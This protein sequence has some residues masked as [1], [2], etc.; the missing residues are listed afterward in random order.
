VVGV[1]RNQHFGLKQVLMPC[2]LYLGPHT[3]WDRFNYL[4]VR[5]KPGRIQDALADIKASWKARIPDIP[6]E[7]HFVDEMIEAL[8][9]SEDRLS[10]LINAF[11]LL[12][13]GISCLGLFGMASFMSQQR[14]KEIGIRK[15]L[16]ASAFRIV[17]LTTG[18]T[19]R[20]V[21]LA[22][23][24]AWPAAYFAVRSWLNN[25]PYRI[26][27]GIE[28]FIVSGLAALA[29]ALLSVIAQAV[30]SALADPSASL[31]YE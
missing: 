7:Y 20:W 25:Y 6:I 13:I 30:K 17:L 19:L 27:I 12:A 24:L 14:T 11:T 16:G 15:V 10:G 5:L 23:I 31:K 2:V 22:N 26:H 29:V 21:I 3:Q 28:V 8:Y 9:Q 18:E 1:Y 4:T